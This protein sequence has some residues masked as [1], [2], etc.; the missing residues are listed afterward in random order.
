LPNESADVVVVTA[1]I[2]RG[3]GLA[4]APHVVAR[5]IGSRREL[6]KVLA[7]LTGEAGVESVLVLGGDC[8]RPAG[9][10]DA[11]PSARSDRAS[12]KARHPQDCDCLLSRGPPAHCLAL[13]RRRF[14][15]SPQGTR[16][17][18]AKYLSGETPE[19]LLV[20]VA[21]A[22]AGEL[23]FGTAG[24]H[25]ITFGDPARSARWAEESAATAVA[26]PRRL[27]NGFGA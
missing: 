11:R 13:R 6:D 25:F 9:E 16:Q 1:A 26:R 5:N 17:S 14:F 21:L 20:E 10:F 19:D 27:Y 3:V 18:G 7:G 15:A 4:P 22:Q 8:D 23:A 24:V 2:L 12:R